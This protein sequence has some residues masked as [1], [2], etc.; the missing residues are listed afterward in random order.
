[1]LTR[2]LVMVR[3]G[4][5]EGNAA[6]MFTGHGASPL[7]A[8]GAR[9]AEAVAGALAALGPAAIYSSDLPRALATA[10]P[11][12][13]RV[14]VAVHADHRLRER[15]MG[16]FVGVPFKVL[17]AEQP[18]AW[19]ALLSRDPEFTPPEGESHRQCAGRMSAALDEILARHATGTVV[20]FS[21]GVVL[22]HALRHLLGASTPGLILATE[23]CGVHRLEWRE[24]GVLRVAALNDTSHLDGLRSS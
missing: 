19:R 1:M 6:R 11:L 18:E 24:F 21:H 23:N 22:H 5:S 9:Q 13:A 16:T 10:A 8:L 14:G 7:T 2:T 17:E 20:V 12:A 15:D 4:E 3:H